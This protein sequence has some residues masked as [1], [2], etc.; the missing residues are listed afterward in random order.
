[1]PDDNQLVFSVIITIA[2]LSAWTLYEFFVF[3]NI[4]KE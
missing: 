1:L 2:A 4:E 3:P